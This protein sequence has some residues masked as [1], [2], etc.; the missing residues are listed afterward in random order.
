[1]GAGGGRD[2]AIYDSSTIVVEPLIMKVH[3]PVYEFL[4]KLLFERTPKG[5][6]LDK[7]MD[8]DLYHFIS[9]DSKQL[10]DVFSIFTERRDKPASV[11]IVLI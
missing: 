9:I 8:F 4:W 6:Q 7:I 11:K 2:I 10:F 5:S 3:H 1:M